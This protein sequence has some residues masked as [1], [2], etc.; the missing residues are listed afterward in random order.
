VLNHGKAATAACVFLILAGCAGVPRLYEASLP[1]AGPTVPEITNHISCEIHAA[2]Q[3][4]KELVGESYFVSVLLTLQVDDSADLTPSLGFITPLTGMGQN[5][6]T[7]VSGDLGETRR[8]TFTTTYTLDTK[9]LDQ[10]A[11]CGGYHSG[12][13]L[14]KLNGDVGVSEIID[15]GTKVVDSGQAVH[16]PTSSDDKSPPSF[17]SL[18]QFTITKSL[19]G[20]GPLWT[21]ARFKGPAGSSGL[22]NGKLLDTDSVILTFARQFPKPPQTPHQERAQAAVDDAN[23]ALS[24]ARRA[25]ASAK[26][27]STAADAALAEA[28]KQL[29]VPPKH[30]LIATLTA[31][32]RTADAEAAHR[33][34][35]LERAQ[36]DEIS[37]EG[38]VASAR[39]GKREADE[40]AAEQ[41]EAA[42]AAA[43]AAAQSLQTTIL[44]QNLLSSQIH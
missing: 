1:P 31:R 12:N 42:P 3:K 21:L 37:A 33:R 23:A 8:R 17:G 24:D 5:V 39:S 11:W 13:R 35:D 22:V 2:M 9:L 36:R 16:I 44:L 38:D 18:I 10:A 15:N 26:T 19:T 43:I 32:A 6:T 4:H 40:A 25:L 41:V 27:L 20:L 7:T 14:L 29:S 28:E 34:A 30:A